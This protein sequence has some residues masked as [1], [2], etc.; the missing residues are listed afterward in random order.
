[1][2]RYIL[3]IGGL[4]IGISSIEGQTVIPATAIFK[5]TFVGRDII[6]EGR[7]EGVIST[8]FEAE[9]TEEG[10][11]VGKL[12]TT[13]AIISG[14]VKG[15]IMAIGVVKCTPTAEISGGVLVCRDLIVE[16]GAIITSNVKMGEEVKLKEGKKKKTTPTRR[17]GRRRRRRRRGRRF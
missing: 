5:G 16:E 9:I 17:R 13:D 15:D 8:D 3:G 1:M 6:I 11:L 12:E 2:G 4:I 14:I 7:V 10:E